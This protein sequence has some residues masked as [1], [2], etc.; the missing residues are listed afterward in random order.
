MYSLAEH[1]FGIVPSLLSAGEVVLLRRELEAL[2][3]APGHRNLA[4]RMPAVAELA[5]SDTIR[6]LL[7]ATTGSKPFLVRSIFFDKTSGA[8]WLVPWHQ[9][10]SIAVAKR[11]DAPGFTAWSVKDGV[12]Y[13]HPPVSIL[14]AIV[15]LRLHLDD[16]DG[17]NGALRVI[18][19]SH[20]HG[21]L[22]TPEIARLR[23]EDAEAV[24]AAKAGDALLM[25]PLL[26]HASSAAEVPHHRRVIHL[27]YS[28]VSLPDG[29]EW[30]E[31]GR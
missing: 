31:G 29:L 2:E 26:L 22:D 28:T 17:S 10:L 30:A 27:E 4:S 14:E 20:R 11:R 23:A 7:A 19:H 6:N 16:C 25:R 21:Q 1:G 5:R 13:V 12:D 15:T 18:P 3:V 24:C 9:D 8:N